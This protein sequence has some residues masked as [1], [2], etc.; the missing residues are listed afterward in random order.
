[1]KPRFTD[2]ISEKGD[3][4]RNVEIIKS[5][6]SSPAVFMT[7]PLHLKLKTWK[8]A[9]WCRT[10]EGACGD[11]QA[12]VPPLDFECVRHMCTFQ[13]ESLF[14]PLARP[15]TDRQRSDFGSR[16]YPAEIVMYQVSSASDKAK[17]SSQCA[18]SDIVR[19]PEII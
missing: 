1:M 19:I 17:L 8:S 14:R 11:P 4:R 18:R 6:S 13:V 12:Q 2:K 10:G 15:T 9:W 3:C 7:M 5:P 16:T